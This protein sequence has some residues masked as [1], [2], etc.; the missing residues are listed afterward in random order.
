MIPGANKRSFSDAEISEVRRRYKAGESIEG[1]A[2]IFSTSH[3]KIRPLLAGIPIRYRAAHGSEPDIIRRA[4]IARRKDGLGFAEICDFVNRSKSYVYKILAK[5]N[6]DRGIEPWVE[7]ARQMFSE[8]KRTHEI[9]RTHGKSV[10]QVQKVVRDLREAKLKRAP[11]PKPRMTHEQHYALRAER[12]AKIVEARLSGRSAL[13]LSKEFKMQADTIRL[14]CFRAGCPYSGLREQRRA[15]RTTRV[16][17]APAI[18]K[19]KHVPTEQEI[20]ERKAAKYARRNAARR[21]KTAQNPKP[22]FRR[23]EHKPRANYVRSDRPKPEKHVDSRSVELQ[24]NP[25]L[26]KVRELLSREQ[27]GHRQPAPITLPR[28]SLLEGPLYD[29]H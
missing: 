3:R 7:P 29:D 21:A 28:I 23:W 13:E 24:R 16:A 6:I 26:V 11:R 14:I 19:V 9:A 27:M 10:R 15:E 5:Y 18:P 1:L 17:K 2:R 25:R 8:G 4:I 20:Q 22:R 12:N